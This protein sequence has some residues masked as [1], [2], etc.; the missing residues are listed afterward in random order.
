MHEIHVQTQQR[1]WSTLNPLSASLDCHRHCGKALF[2]G[3]LTAPNDAIKTFFYVTLVTQALKKKINHKSH[4]KNV[5][6]IRA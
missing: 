4:L 3:Y 6:Q 2:P 1:I 5:F